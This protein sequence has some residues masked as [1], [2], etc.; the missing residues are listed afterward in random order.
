MRP[1]RQP[2][3]QYQVQFGSYYW[4][5]HSG[6]MQSMSDEVAVLFDD[7]YHAGLTL[8]KHGSPDVVEAY[9]RR[10]IQAYKDSNQDHMFR[11]LKL[12]SGKLDVDELNRA[13]STSGYR[14]SFLPE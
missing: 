11:Y 10:M 3:F 9:F 14:P 5:G 6:L 8:L 2:P 7:D 13:I 4:Y 12:V 1:Q